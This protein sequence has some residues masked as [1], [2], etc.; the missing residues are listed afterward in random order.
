MKSRDGGCSGHFLLVQSWFHFWRTDQQQH[1]P[2]WPTDI[3]NRAVCTLPLSNI[4]GAG[5]EPLLDYKTNF[6]LVD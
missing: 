2:E 3:L 5:S 6:N 4:A 1:E